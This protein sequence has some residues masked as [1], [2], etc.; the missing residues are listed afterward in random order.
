MLLHDA[1]KPLRELVFLLNTLLPIDNLQEL[2]VS[3]SKFTLYI[4]ILRFYF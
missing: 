1:L 2:L 3:S 4:L